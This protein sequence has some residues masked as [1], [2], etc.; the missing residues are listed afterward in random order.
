MS[1]RMPPAKT[2]EELNFLE[3]AHRY[4]K[5]RK[6]FEQKASRSDLRNTRSKQNTFVTGKN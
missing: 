5:K 4:M 6:G 2:L 1:K 3:M